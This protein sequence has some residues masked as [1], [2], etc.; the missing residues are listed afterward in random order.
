MRTSVG[1]YRRTGVLGQG[2]MDGVCAAHADRLDRTVAIKTLRPDSAD[3]S[4]RERLQRGD[5]EP[6]IA[7]IPRQVDIPDPEGRYYVARHLVH[8][9]DIDRGLEMLSNVVD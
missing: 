2:G 4:S 8:A 6:S 5:R 1:R 3:P 7:A 9:G